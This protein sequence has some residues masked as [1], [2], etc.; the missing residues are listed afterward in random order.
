V[1]DLGVGG[2]RRRARYYVPG[3]LSGDRASAG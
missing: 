1:R 3:D 2:E